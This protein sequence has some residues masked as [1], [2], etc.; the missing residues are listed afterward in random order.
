MK[1]LP[2]CGNGRYI[3]IKNKKT[4]LYKSKKTRAHARIFP[5]SQLKNLLLKLYS[6]VNL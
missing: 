1:E 5:K 6:T 2:D 4:N 3:Q